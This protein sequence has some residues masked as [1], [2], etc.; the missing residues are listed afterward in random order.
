MQ[1]NQTGT[2]YEVCQNDDAERLSLIFATTLVL[3]R[4]NLFRGLGLSVDE[5]ERSS[6]LLIADADRGEPGTLH[7]RGIKVRVAVRLFSDSI[8]GFNL[9]LTK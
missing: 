5:R 7:S 3:W 4:E 8:R 1:T 9:A 6:R 2:S